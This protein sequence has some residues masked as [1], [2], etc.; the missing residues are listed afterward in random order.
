M[1]RVSRRH[2]GRNPLTR[3][4]NTP[5]QMAPTPSPF[6]RYKSVVAHDHLIHS[7]H[8]SQISFSHSLLSRQRVPVSSTASQQAFIYPSHR[9]LPFSAACNFPRRLLRATAADLWRSMAIPL[10]VQCGT[11]Q[12]PCRCKIVG[13]T[14]G[15]VAFLITAVVEWPLGAAIWCFRH[16]KGRRIM[17][18][19]NRVVYP[20][21]ASAIPF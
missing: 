17:H 5:G 20:R 9:R 2:A 19:P 4:T 8:R 6:L 7:Q 10:C 21:V 15:V 12:N 3:V 1:E 11:H 14:L 16:Q 18:H 13:P